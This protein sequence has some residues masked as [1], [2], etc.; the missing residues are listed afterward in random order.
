MNTNWPAVNRG[1]PRC[2]VE[3]LDAR[4]TGVASVLCNARSQFSMSIHF[5]LVDLRL[6]VRIAE[7]NSLTRGAEAI[8]ISVPAASTRIKNVEESIGTKLLNRTSQGVTL[9]PPGQAFVLHARQVMAQIES[10]NGDLQ[11]YSKGIKGHLRLFANATAIGEFLPPVLRRFL[12]SHPD[13]NIDLRER[14]SHD[15]VRAVTDGQTDIGVVAGDVRTENLAVIPYHRDKLVLVVPAGHELVGLPAIAFEDTLDYD[16][17]GLHEA[18]ALNGFLRRICTESNRTLRTRIQVG[19]FEAACR[20]VEETVGIAVMQ[21]SAARRHAQ[22]MKIRIVPLA[23]HW[24]LRELKICVRDLEALPSFA[25]DL[26]SLLTQDA[27]S[28]EAAGS[29]GAARTAK[30]AVD[31]ANNARARIVDA[32]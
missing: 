25:R 18:S 23:N 17:I 30:V 19:S 9:T 29:E 27:Q 31:A 24:S 26:V 2:L 10:L 6:M 14:L 8:H 3:P 22:T 32:A 28:G 4:L 11:E 7:F 16:H 21:A 20:M 5:D 15:I 12:L 1:I 13:V